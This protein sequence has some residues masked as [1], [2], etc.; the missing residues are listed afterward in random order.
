VLVDLAQTA[1]IEDSIRL[2]KKVLDALDPISALHHRKV[3]RA[4][5]VVLKS[6]DIPSV[7]VETG[8]ISNPQEEQRLNNPAYQQKIANSLWQ[9]INMYMHQYV[10]N[11]R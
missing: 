1:T 5:F 2:G 7:L 4:P 9:G 3:E 11:K 10:V 8:F 6:P